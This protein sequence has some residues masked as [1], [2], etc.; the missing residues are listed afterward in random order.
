MTNKMS[1]GEQK[2]FSILARAGL[3][4]SQEVSFSGLNGSHGV[5]LRFDF[6]VYDSRGRIAYLLE[7]DGIQHFQFTPYFHKSKIDFRRQ[8]E[9]DSKKNKFCLAKGIPLIRIPYWD[10]DNITL[11]SIFT[12]P[13]YRVKNKDHNLLLAEV[14]K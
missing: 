13:I 6:A 1:K 12:N 2:I 10:I 14:K 8:L 7:F 3:K 5:P 9:W 11:K 4:F